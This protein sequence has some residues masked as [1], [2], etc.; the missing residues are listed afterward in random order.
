[1]KPRGSIPD[2][3]DVRVVVR[4][5]SR[6]EGSARLSVLSIARHFGLSNTTFRRHFADVVDEIRTINNIEPVS[7]GGG[8]RST[9]PCHDCDRLRKENSVLRADVEAAAAS[10]QR[11]ALENYRLRRELEALSGVVNIASRNQTGVVSEAVE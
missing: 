10:V 7:R 11:L 2:I 8:S 5:L 1:M 4:D 9:G 3:D 6:G